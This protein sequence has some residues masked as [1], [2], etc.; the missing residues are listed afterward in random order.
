MNHRKYILFIALLMTAIS[1]VFVSCTGYDDESDARGIGVIHGDVLSRATAYT[2]PVGDC[3]LI[4]SWW[5]VFV[6]GSNKIAKVVE[7]EAFK[8]YAVKREDFV[9]ELAAGTYDVYS[10][11]NISKATVE[12][13]AGVSAGTIAEGATMPDLDNVEYDINSLIANGTLKDDLETPIPMSGKKTVTVT[14]GEQSLEFEVIRMMA[15]IEFIFRNSCKNK[16]ITLKSLTFLPVNEGIIPLMPNY[17]TLEYNNEKD[18]VLID[19]DVTTENLTFDFTN[20]TK[21]PESIILH[22]QSYSTESFTHCFY[23]RESLAETHPTK[24]FKIEMV[25]EGRDDKENEPVYTISSKDYRGLNRNDYLQIP[26]RFTDY[27]VD[28]AV[29]FYPPIGGFPPVIVENKPTEFYCTFGTEGDFQIIPTVYDTDAGSYLPLSKY[30]YELLEVEDPDGIF[31]TGHEPQINTYTG[32]LTGTLNTGLGTASVYVHV[33][34]PDPLDP[35]IQQDFWR[36]I[37]IIRKNS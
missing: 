20:K 11:A 2:A 7:R 22:K 17:S 1:N 16:D 29:D 24:H 37:Y 32:E 21:Y 13:L 12:G 4:N 19:H 8:T 3:E 23:I 18:P 28:L 6:D 14:E 36:R 31:V 10:F 5:V 25:I 35:S 30:N 26:I 27:K 33:Y 9:L 34:I 15:K